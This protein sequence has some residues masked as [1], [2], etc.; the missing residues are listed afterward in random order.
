MPNLTHMFKLNLQRAAAYI[1]RL[2]FFTRLAI[3]LMVL[4]EVVRLTPW[5]DIQAWGRLEP[6]EIGLRTSMFPAYPFP[7]SR[8]VWCGWR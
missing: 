5:W 2:P 6:D 4:C 1:D 8:V 7:P 3:V